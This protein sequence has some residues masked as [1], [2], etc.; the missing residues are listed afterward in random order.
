[1]RS[2]MLSLLCFLIFIMFPL[3]AYIWVEQ[4]KN[5]PK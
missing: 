4:R 2:R 3:I 1:M 5:P